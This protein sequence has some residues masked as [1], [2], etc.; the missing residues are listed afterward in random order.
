MNL[1]S[2]DIMGNGVFSYVFPEKHALGTSHDNG[3]ARNCL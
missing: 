3:N 1:E 2:V